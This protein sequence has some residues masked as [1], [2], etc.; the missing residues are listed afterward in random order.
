M[1]DGKR[2]ARVESES[3]GWKAS[4]QGGKRVDRV[5]SESTGAGA[6]GDGLQSVDWTIVGFILGM[7]TERYVRVMSTYI[8]IFVLI[9]GDQTYRFWITRADQLIRPKTPH[10]PPTKV[11]VLH[12]TYL[13]VTAKLRSM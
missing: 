9:D 11:C 12:P 2:V 13:T 4:R 7:Y 5:E 1:Q 10:P 8:H 3:T 6:K